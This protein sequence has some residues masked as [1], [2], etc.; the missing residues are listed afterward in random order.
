MGSL[1]DLENPSR[2][3]HLVLAGSGDVDL[4]VYDTLKACHGA[5][6]DSAYTVE[7]KVQFNEMLS[8]VNVQPYMA[9]KWLF[10]VVVNRSIKPLLLKYKGIFESQSSCFILK[11]ARYKDYKEIKSLVPQCN[12]LYLTLFR[13]RDIAYLFNKLGMPQKLLDFVSGSYSKE[14]E[15]VLEL[16]KKIIE[17]TEVKTQKDIVKLVGV[18]AGSVNS[19]VFLLLADPPTTKSGLGRVLKKR[20]Q[21][22]V[23]LAD[24]YGVVRLRNYLKS[25]VKDFLEIKTLYMQGVIFNRL[26]DIPEPFDEGRLSKYSFC[27]DRITKDIP[28]KRLVRLSNMLNDSYWSS[29]SDV[30]G[31]LYGYYGDIELAGD[32]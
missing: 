5:T 13:R 28:Y 31:F 18:S 32:K 1:R 29:S 27:L 22:A 7:S 2:V 17:G 11:V 26:K 16:R 24:A 3:I 4:F 15:K 8:L 21:L 19:L 20:V 14:P 12:D 9:G 30:I 25:V 6:V 23:G 10:T